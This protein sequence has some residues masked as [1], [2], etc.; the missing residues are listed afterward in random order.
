M[1]IRGMADAVV[2]VNEAIGIPKPLEAR[3]AH[4]SVSLAYPVAP[5]LPKR[6]V[7]KGLTCRFYNMQKGPVQ[8]SVTPGLDCGG[9]V[10]L[11]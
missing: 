3:Q 5:G 2:L 7:D 8:R 10:N 9:L 6:P 11:C 4:R 1:E